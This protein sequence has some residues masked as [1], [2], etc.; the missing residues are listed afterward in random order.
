MGLDIKTE[1]LATGLRQ[2]ATSETSQILDNKGDQRLSFARSLMRC[3]RLRGRQALDVQSPSSCCASANQTP[4]P[5]AP[6]ACFTNSSRQ[7]WPL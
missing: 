5:K 4:P 7:R 6:M 1:G 2:T 3:K